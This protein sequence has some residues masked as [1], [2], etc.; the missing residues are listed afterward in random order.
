MSLA[1][2]GILPTCLY[3]Y[4]AKLI[5]IVKPTDFKQ[6]R[7]SIPI[8]QLKKLIWEFLQ[9]HCRPSTDN[10]KILIFLITCHNSFLGERNW[11]ENVSNTLLHSVH[12]ITL[13]FILCTTPF[14]TKNW[15]FFFFKFFAFVAL[16]ASQKYRIVQNLL[17][18]LF[19]C[20]ATLYF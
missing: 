19:L 2:L 17:Y 13:W 5:L 16:F 11:F 10:K 20:Q 12:S 8:D 15:T 7:F 18:C 1:K 14:T 3:N 9:T 6:C 4:Q